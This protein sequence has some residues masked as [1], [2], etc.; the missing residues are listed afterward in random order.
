[1]SERG[2][3]S[4]LRLTKARLHLPTWVPNEGLAS[5]L[6]ILANPVLMAN[7][8]EKWQ[9]GQKGTWCGAPPIG[10]QEA[11]AGAKCSREND[12]EPGGL[13]R[14]CSATRAPRLPSSAA[15]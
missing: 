7:V 2:A 3:P 10:A 13:P 1:M 6:G 12:R 4:D 11:T 14:P 15:L 9:A 8:S 5:A